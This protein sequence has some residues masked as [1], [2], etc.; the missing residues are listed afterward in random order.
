MQSTTR[1]MV[2]GAEKGAVAGAALV[3]LFGAAVVIAA[4]LVQ[5]KVDLGVVQARWVPSGREFV[6]DLQVS[7]LMWVVPVLGAAAGAWLAR[8]AAQRHVRRARG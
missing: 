7:A 2:T 1:Q 5:G 8:G 4:I 6:L 3:V